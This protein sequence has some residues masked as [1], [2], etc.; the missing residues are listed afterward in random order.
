MNVFYPNLATIYPH[1]SHQACVRD[2]NEELQL[3]KDGVRAAKARENSLREEL[4]N[5]N[6]DLQRSQKSHHKLQSEKEALEDQL[7]E[8]KRKVQRLS[9]GLQVRPHVFPIQNSSSPL[10]T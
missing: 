10:F 8:Q 7:N 6:K 3:S 5:L 4:E 9:S 1:V 2:L